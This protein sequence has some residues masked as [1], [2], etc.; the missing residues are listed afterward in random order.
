M[1]STPPPSLSTPTV[2]VS[3]NPLSITVTGSTTVTVTVS[4]GNGTPTG[5]VELFGSNGFGGTG[6]GTATLSG[7]AAQF[8]IP[9]SSLA[10]GSNGLAATYM[11]DASSSSS[12]TSASGTGSVTVSQITPTVTV[13]PNPSSISTTESTT[14]TVTVS[15]GSGNPTPIGSVELAS[16]TNF[17]G[18]ATLN[19]GSTQFTVYASSLSVGSNTLSAIFMTAS[20]AYP[21]ALGTGSVTV[22]AIS[23][24]ITPT[25]TISPN[26]SSISTTGSTTVTVTVSGGSGNPPP[27]GDV[28]LNAD[29]NVGAAGLTPSGVS[30]S[31]DAVLTVPASS[32]SIGPNTLTAHFWSASSTYTN[33]S[34]TGSVIV[35]AP[36]LMTPTVTVSANPSSITTAGM[37][38]GQ[39]IP[40]SCEGSLGPGGSDAL[41]ITSLFASSGAGAQI[42]LSGQNCTA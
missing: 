2:T 17:L 15:G 4:G 33:A 26:P 18:N 19:N 25:V 39:S 36:S 7:G 40:Y 37:A 38:L 28:T 42:D 8:T 23:P 5:A 24:A 32:L 9:A 30:G 1:S 35:T 22:T 16:G 13:S 3:A 11:P 34:G 29:S 31:S 12:Y 27:T 6:L 20:Y 41:N 14:V 10:I 21:S